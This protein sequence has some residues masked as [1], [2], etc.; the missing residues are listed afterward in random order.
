MKQADKQTNPNSL[1]TIE[2]YY[3]TNPLIR[4]L[5]KYKRNNYTSLWT[6][7][8]SNRI[9]DESSFLKNFSLKNAEEMIELDNVHFET[10]NEI[11]DLD[12][13]WWFSSF[14]PPPSVSQGKKSH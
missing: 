8:Q 10:P 2:G 4:K 7:C 5:I 14:D 1:F 12:N 13:S 9:V 11:M 6:L 3:D